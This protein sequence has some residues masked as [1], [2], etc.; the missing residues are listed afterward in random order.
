MEGTALKKPAGAS[1]VSDDSGVSSKLV[2]QIQA[3]VRARPVASSLDKSS[4]TKASG[5]TVLG[6][7]ER[8]LNSHGTSSE[9][10]TGNSCTEGVLLILTDR[11]GKTI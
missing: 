8:Y 4:S 9:G 6:G 11:D 2:N 3:L 7:T 10:V 1:D 5:F